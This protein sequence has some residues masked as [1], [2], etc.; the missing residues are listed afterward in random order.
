MLNMLLQATD[1]Q[2]RALPN[3]Q[4][5]D[6][7][8]TLM[9]AGHETTA[10]LLTWTLGL[11]ASNPNMQDMVAHTKTETVFDAC[12]R[13]TAD[14]LYIKAVLQE[15]LR[16][17]PPVWIFSRRAIDNDVIGG[18]SVP[19]GTT[20]TMCTYALHRHPAFWD[21]P[22][23]FDP[24]RF[25]RTS[26]GLMPHPAHFP[27][28]AGPRTCIGGHLAMTEAQMVLSMICRRFRL[29]LASGYRLEPEPLVTLRP[30][31]GLKLILETRSS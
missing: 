19:A 8:M 27:F 7:V 24:E 14:T 9:L 6:E 31:G 5:R 4:I 12:Q 22:D 13:A 23:R 1:E 30:R 17:Y 21:V 2:G 3:T 18:Y 29:K 10:N 20:V 15:S 26:D 28:G 25:A 11:L 16:L